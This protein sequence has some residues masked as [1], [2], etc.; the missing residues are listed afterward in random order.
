MDYFEKIKSIVAEQLNVDPETIT[1]NTRFDE[2]N[3]D[4]LDVVEVI[5]TLEQEFDIQI[6][7]IEEAEKIKNIRRSCRSYV[8]DHG[9]E[10]ILNM[11]CRLK[12]VPWGSAFFVV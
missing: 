3:A 6:P 1:M 2:L 11:C 5:M 4:S 7:G 12:S 8:S 10:I 9:V